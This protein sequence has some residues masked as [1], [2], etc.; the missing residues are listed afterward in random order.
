MEKIN[1]DL[2]N[3]L[4]QYLTI[5]NNGPQANSQA[6]NQTVA[7]LDLEKQYLTKAYKQIAE[8]MIQLDENKKQDQEKL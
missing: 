7:R 2:L 8:N 1:A 3:C 5:M 4:H 6:Q